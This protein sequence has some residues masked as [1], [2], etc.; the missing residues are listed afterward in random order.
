MEMPFLF[1]YAVTGIKHVMGGTVESHN[2]PFYKLHY[3][4]MGH[5]VLLANF[6]G[7]YV[8]L[9]STAVR[10]ERGLVR[11]IRSDSKDSL[12]YFSEARLQGCS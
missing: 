7:M 10:V 1:Q 8:R 9:K 12:S 6:V 4:L 2:W 3:S 11:C 5:S